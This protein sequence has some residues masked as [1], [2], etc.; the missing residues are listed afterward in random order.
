MKFTEEHEWLRV[1]GDVVVV[2]VTAHAAEQLGD[3][4][5]VELPEVDTEVSKDDE[6]CVIESVKAASD[7]LAPLD[8]EIVEVN[9]ALSLIESRQFLYEFIT[10]EGI[11]PVMYAK[12][13]DASANDWKTEPGKRHTLWEAYDDFEDDVLDIETD[14]ENGLITVSILWTDPEIATQWSN[15]IVDR[16]NEKLRDKAIDEATRTLEYLNKELQQTTVVEIQESLYELVKTQKAKIVA[17]N[18]H[19]EYAFKI[20]DPAVVPEEPA[21]PYLLVILIVVG[22]VIGMFIGVTVALLL[23]LIRQAQPEGE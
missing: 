8:G 18:V 10:N 15:D 5:F 12:D 16:I 19:N 23:H 2:G 3:V 4:V 7:I 13:W 9:E 11:M 6:V 20:M 1:E 14:D 17:A 22:S 21:V